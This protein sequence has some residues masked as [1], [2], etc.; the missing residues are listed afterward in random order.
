[1]ET[2]WISAALPPTAA[3]RTTI[4][5]RDA[6]VVCQASVIAP[7]FGSCSGWSVTPST[8]D[9]GSVTIG[10]SVTRS[11][12]I[13]APAD[14]IY[15]GARMDVILA[16]PDFT[17]TDGTYVKHVSLD[18]PVNW[19]FDVRFAPTVAGEESFGL[20]TYRACGPPGSPAYPCQGVLGT[21]VGVRASAGRLGLRPA[22]WRPVEASRR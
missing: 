18:S 6:P 20:T 8:L 12:H 17:F 19:T 11:I 5:P 3:A 14:C 10:Q 16:G 4:S 7:E 15:S 9:F 13:S 2:A 1:M 21:G 22:P